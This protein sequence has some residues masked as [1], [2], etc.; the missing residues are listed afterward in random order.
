M[1]IELISNPVSLAATGEIATITARLTDYYG[2]GL[3]KGIVVNWNTTSGNLSVPQS[4]TDEDSVATVQLRSSSVIGSATVTAVTSEDGGT[5][6]IIIPFTDKWVP[7]APAYTGWADYGAAYNCAAWTPATSSVASGASFTQS[8]T[9]AQNQIAYRQDREQSA[10]TGAIRNRGNAQP[11][12]QTILIT[13]TQTAV[14]TKPADVSIGGDDSVRYSKM[15]SDR[16]PNARFGFDYFLSLPN[17][18]TTSAFVISGN[19]IEVEKRTDTQYRII[20]RGN[21]SHEGVIRFTA[22]NGGSTVIKD[23]RVTIN[24]SYGGGGH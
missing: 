17:G 5:G 21:G 3:G 8:S 19:K 2:V 22:T 24:I 1:K 12:Y 16:N 7:I 4:E 15:S 23:V 20:A 13:L 11:I 18:G 9:C 10:V 6:S 14:G